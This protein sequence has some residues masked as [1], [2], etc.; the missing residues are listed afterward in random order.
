MI[1]RC[2]KLSLVLVCCLS[3]IGRAESYTRFEDLLD[4]DREGVIFTDVRKLPLKKD[5]TI[6]D[7]SVVV[8]VWTR[9]PEDQVRDRAALKDRPASPPRLTPGQI[10]TLFKKELLGLPTI[11]RTSSSAV[12]VVDYHG[13]N[14][15]WLKDEPAVQIFSFDGKRQVALKL[16]ELFTNGW[17]R[18]FWHGG[19][20][21][22]V[23]WLGDAWFDRSGRRL[24]LMTAEDF[25]A[26]HNREGV[27]VD[28]DTGKV[29]PVNHAAIQRE[30]SVVDDRFLLSLFVLAQNRAI[31]GFRETAG[32]LFK[33]PAVPIEV[34]LR[35]AAYLE[36][37]G[38]LAAT[39]LLDE[40]AALGEVAPKDLKHPLI[41]TESVYDDYF[42]NTTI[43]F[44][45]DLRRRQAEAERK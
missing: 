43:R 41:P 37:Y 13:L 45:E 6:R 3:S 22:S 5:A 17:E 4:V 38:N 35:A 36:P 16:N 27:I 23:H 44:A 15:W 18:Y 8:T 42:W 40:F 2:R 14:A 11:V 34:K 24:F 31:P 12:A 30:L 26:E 9:M 19:N 39:K 28:L 25:T 32:R 20:G 21:G 10:R 7:E 29:E 33:D 1:S